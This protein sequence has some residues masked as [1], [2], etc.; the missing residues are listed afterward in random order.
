MSNHCSVLYNMLLDETFNNIVNKA[1]NNAT[2]T[3]FFASKFSK[4]LCSSVKNDLFYLLFERA[5]G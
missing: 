5:I 3:F 1:F 2:L 4:L